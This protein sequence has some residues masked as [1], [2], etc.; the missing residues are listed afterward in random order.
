ME[1]AVSQLDKLLS[2]MMVAMCVS[3]QYNIGSM[4]TLTN[5]EYCCGITTLTNI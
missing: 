1:I 5:N 2:F 4:V 3:S